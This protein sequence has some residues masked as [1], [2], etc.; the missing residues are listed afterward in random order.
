MRLLFTGKGSA[1]SW[2]VRG[3]QLGHACRG[4]VIPMASLSECFDAELIVAVKK[5]PPQL[6]DAIRRSRRKWVLDVVDLYPQPAC[7]GWNQAQSIAWVRQQ[8]AT[9]NPHAVIWPTQRMHQDCADGRPSMV[10][11][12]HHRPDIAQ[13]PIREHVKT[14]GYEGR[15]AYLGGWQAL[16]ERECMRRG[17]KFVT[18][19]AQLA[20]LDVVVAVRGDQWDSYAARNWKSNVKLANAHG[21]G[22]PF[23]GN[24]ECGYLETAAGCEF[25]ADNGN[26]LPAIFDRL[27]PHSVRQQIAD[28]FRKN[29]YPLERAA[30]D[31]CRFLRSL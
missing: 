7:S 12:H 19:P 13:N 30:E 1:G 9:L 24:P 25:W 16:L 2:Q 14:V 15:P 20:D 22:T 17:W 5:T 6:L 31:L 8:V 21:S 23:I 11:P 10:L 3:Q 4:W 26:D 29:A 27:G 18:N 28:R